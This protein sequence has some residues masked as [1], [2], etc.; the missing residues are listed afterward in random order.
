[1]SDGPAHEKKDDKEQVPRGI[2]AALRYSEPKG[3]SSGGSG[4]GE[5]PE[6]GVRRE[7]PYVTHAVQQK[8]EPERAAEPARSPAAALYRAHEAAYDSSSAGAAGDGFVG[9]SSFGL[10]V[11]GG[12]PLQGTQRGG[13][14]HKVP[15]GGRASWKDRPERGSQ[16]GPPPAHPLSVASPL[17]I[18]VAGGAWTAPEGGRAGGELAA[19]A[20]NLA[21][22]A[23]EAL[24]PPDGKAAPVQTKKTGAKLREDAGNLHRGAGDAL[25]SGR[26]EAAAQAPAAPRKGA[27]N[28]AAAIGAAWQ[29]LWD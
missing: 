12:A 14:P 17:G 20:G 7:G 22:G 11:Y 26:G 6:K 8:S 2:N 4:G 9:P 10:G 29:G 13:D 19:P 27:A 5:G 23:G 16:V 24:R 3:S 21:R 18:G 28:A 25:T 15:A 1:M